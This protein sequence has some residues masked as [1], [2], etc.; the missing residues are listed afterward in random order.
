ML[1]TYAKLVAGHVV[2]GAAILAG[3]AVGCGAAVGVAVRRRG[4][5]GGASRSHWSPYDRVGVVNADP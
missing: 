5:G 2:R 3:G 4:G 1:R